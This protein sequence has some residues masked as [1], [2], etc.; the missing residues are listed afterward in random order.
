[1]IDKEEYSYPKGCSCKK[2]N[3]DKKYCECYAQNMKC[4][5]FCKCVN[6]NNAEEQVSMDI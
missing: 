6:C 3:C 5:S 1:M 4:T 2:I